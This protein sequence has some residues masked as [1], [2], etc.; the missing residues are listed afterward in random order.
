M[1]ETM[2][3]QLGNSKGVIGEVEAEEDG[4]GWGEYL[5][6][7]ICLDI[8][9]P[10]A[11][12]R[13]LK[14]KDV[15]TWVA[16]QYEKLPKFRFQ[17]GVIRN[18]TMECSITRGGQHPGDTSKAQFG[19]WLRAQPSFTR[20]GT[21]RGWSERVG[22]F[23]THAN[24]H[25]ADSGSHARGGDRHNSK[26][27]DMGKTSSSSAELAPTVVRSGGDRRSQDRGEQVAG[28]LD[29]FKF[30]ITHGIAT[31]GFSGEV[32]MQILNHTGAGAN[33]AASSKSGADIS[34]TCEDITGQGLSKGQM[35][36]GQ[37]SA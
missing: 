35:I 23:S 29:K 8:T 28:V 3:V 25:S 13:F 27:K 9:K 16:F 24:T 5:R 12:G 37:D 11:R 7:R 34:D 6:V 10:L 22:D 21:G 33:I 4:I 30:G 36:N 2:G 1:C 32:P 19:S 20:S 14:M 31:G 18:G 15:N 26:Q 17:C